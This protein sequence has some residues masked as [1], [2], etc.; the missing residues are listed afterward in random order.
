LSL[1]VWNRAKKEEEKIVDCLAGKRNGNRSEK[2]AEEEEEEE[3]EEVN[4][5]E[6]EAYCLL[7][8]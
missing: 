4:P 6:K 5:V 3:A 2:Q 7:E 8:I 1:S